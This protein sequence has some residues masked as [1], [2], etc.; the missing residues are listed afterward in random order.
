MPPARNAPAGSSGGRDTS[1][2][3]RG[4]EAE[5]VRLVRGGDHHEHAQRIDQDIPRRR[6]QC[7]TGRAQPPHLHEREQQDRR[8]ARDERNRQPR[9]A[10]DDVADDHHAENDPARAED[11]RIADRAGGI[12][13]SRRIVQLTNIAAEAPAK[14]AGPHKESRD[15]R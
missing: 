2:Q 4:Q 11:E 10:A 15:G 3:R 12:S 14:G 13:H 1:A 9:L 5:Q 6:P 7:L 8:A